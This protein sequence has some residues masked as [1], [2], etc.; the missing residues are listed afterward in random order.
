MSFFI[1]VP[2][3]VVRPSRVADKTTGKFREEQ[4]LVIVHPD[5]LTPVQA[6]ILLPSD[7]QP[8]AVGDYE[9]SSDSIQPGQYGRPEFRLVVG[10]KIEPKA[11]K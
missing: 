7:G 2:R 9:M 6:S 1:R 3:I 10:P 11:A 8:Y 4:L 5:Q